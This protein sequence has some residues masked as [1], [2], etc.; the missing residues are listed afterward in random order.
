MGLVRARR[1]VVGGGCTR[2]ARC[3]H[4]G[5]RHTR[6]LSALHDGDQF[7]VVSFRRYR[8]AEEFTAD[9]AGNC[10]LD[11]YTLQRLRLRG[12]TTTTE[13]WEVQSY[14]LELLSLSLSLSM[15]KR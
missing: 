15:R 9:R 8:R 4:R 2:A 6:Q 14:R 10:E 12:A 13:I 5:E 7:F 1:V 3:G 11:M